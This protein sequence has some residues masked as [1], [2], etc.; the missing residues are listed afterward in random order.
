[1]IV[2]GANHETTSNFSIKFKEINSLDRALYEEESGLINFAIIIGY[3]INGAPN[4]ISKI[5]FNIIKPTTM[6]AIVNNISKTETPL[7]LSSV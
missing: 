5:S 1:M 4:N 6:E 2:Q 3:P 7:L